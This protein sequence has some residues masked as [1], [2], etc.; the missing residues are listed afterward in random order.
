MMWSDV[1]INEENIDDRCETS[2]IVS[3]VDQSSQMHEKVYKDLA[4]IS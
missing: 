4:F 3:S 2:G 1:G